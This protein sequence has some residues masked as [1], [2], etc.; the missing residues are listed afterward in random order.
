MVPSSVAKMNTAGFPGVSGKSVVPL[1]T[2]PVGVPVGLEFGSPEGMV[3]TRDFGLPVPSY[4]VDLPAP[5]SEIHQGVPDPRDIPQ[6]LTRFGSVTG[7]MP[8]ILDTRLVCL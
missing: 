1:K 8:G 2:C 4:R 3:T 6:G 7:A 5:L